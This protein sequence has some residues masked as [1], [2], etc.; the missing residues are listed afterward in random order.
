MDDFSILL[1][2]IA[3]IYATD[4]IYILGKG[5]SI[6]QISPQLF[7]GS[8]VIALNDA[9]RIAPADITLFH[10]EWVAD[11]LAQSG[12]RSRLYIAPRLFDAGGKQ[13]WVAPHQPLDQ[14]SAHLLMQRFMGEH[15]VLEDVLFLSALHVA[16]RI[17]QLRGRRQT[18]YMVGFDFDPNAGY[19]RAIDTDFAHADAQTLALRISPQ[20]HYFVHALYMLRESLLDVRHVGNR[21]FSALSPSELNATLQPHHRLLDPARGDRVMVVAELTTNHFGDRL[22][23]ERMIRASRAA[24][25]DWVKLQKRDVEGFYTREQLES[26][27]VS[28]FG[29]TFGD[30]RRQLELDADDFEFVD[31][32]CREIG[33]GWFASVLDRNSYDFIRRFRPRL[34]KLPSTISEHRDYLA[35]VARD[36]EGSVVLSTGMTDAAYE[37]FVLSHFTRCESLYLLQCNSA[38]PTPPEDCNVGVVKHYHALSRHHRRIVPGYSS[39]DLGWRASALAVAAGARMVE[40][41]VKL[42]NTEWAHFDAVA[43]DLSTPEFADYVNN[44]RESELMLGTGRKTVNRS[45]HHKY[46]P[47]SRV[48]TS[49]SV[50]ENR[51]L[52]ATEAEQ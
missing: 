44:I 6:D 36:F 33:I 1:R 37:E 47:V 22:R 11:G 2:D 43:M 50:D 34:I 25:A 32:L 28:P 4:T 19:S 10:A 42:G 7:S 35:Y 26:P 51:R 45:E 8:L 20:E 38:Y 13:V 18:V 48:A 41:H 3:S 31:R 9:E 23:L 27:Y 49:E 46:V 16:R 39:H 5:Q 52:C 30:Y 14:E 15:F 17:A 21:S 12:H 24:G 29:R 40:K